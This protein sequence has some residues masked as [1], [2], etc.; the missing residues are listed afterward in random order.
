MQRRRENHKAPASFDT[1]FERNKTIDVI[2]N[3]ENKVR[4]DKTRQDNPFVKVT[5][6][7]FDTSGINQSII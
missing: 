5:L 1:S 3:K 7:Y 6:G 2:D 4:Q